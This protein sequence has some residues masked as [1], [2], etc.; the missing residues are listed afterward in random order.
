MSGMSFQ[1]FE[2]A[3]TAFTAHEGLDLALAHPWALWQAGNTPSEALDIIKK[4][5]RNRAAAA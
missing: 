5:Q 3:L 1:S 4:E 2:Q